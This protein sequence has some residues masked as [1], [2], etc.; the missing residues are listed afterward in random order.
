MIIVM[1]LCVEKLSL[2]HRATFISLIVVI[3]IPVGEVV[4]FFGLGIVDSLS[5]T[6][7]HLVVIM[8]LLLTAT[9]PL[10]DCQHLVP[11]GDFNDGRFTIRA[12]YVA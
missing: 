9:L 3:L 7:N 4:S 2:S 8:L 5:L 12:G 1:I 11:G 10:I 6:E